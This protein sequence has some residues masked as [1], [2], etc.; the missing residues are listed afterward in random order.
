MVWIYLLCIWFNVTFHWIC[1]L[2][3]C[4][5]FIVLFFCKNMLC[6]FIRPLWKIAV[7][8]RVFRPYLE[9]NKW[10]K[11]I[12]KKKYKNYNFNSSRLLFSLFHFM[13]YYFRKSK[14]CRFTWNSKI[15]TPYPEAEADPAIPMKDRLPMLVIHSDSPTYR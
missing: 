3:M 4:I 10:N 12:L 13:N 8:T 15:A 11:F 14:S 9:I 7:L 5:S 1:Y 2:F 6:I